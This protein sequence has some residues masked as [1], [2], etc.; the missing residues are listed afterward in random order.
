[1]LDDGRR[2][3]LH[4][5]G[6]RVSAS[7]LSLVRVEGQAAVFAVH[8]GQ[9]SPLHVR[10]V[11]GASFDAAAERARWLE[12]IRPRPGWIEAQSIAEP[13]PRR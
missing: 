2:A 13:E 6:E 9:A 3:H 8:G 5:V 10:V 4:C 12:T 7:D 1:V 11:V